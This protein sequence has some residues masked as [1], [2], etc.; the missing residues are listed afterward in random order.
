MRRLGKRWKRLHQ[1]IYPASLLIILHYAWSQKADWDPRP[2]AYGAVLLVLLG[3]RVPALRKRIA[4][5]R[6]GRRG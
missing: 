3:M 4:R 5:W 1:L 2:L 6:Q